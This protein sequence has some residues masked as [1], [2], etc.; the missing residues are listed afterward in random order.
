MLSKT[1]KFI[2]TS[3]I[4]ITAKTKVTFETIR[5]NLVDH[6]SLKLIKND[7]SLLYLIKSNDSDYYSTIELFEDKISFIT[8]SNSFPSLYSNDSIMK[9]ILLLSF[10]KD[11]YVVELVDLYP[12][13]IELFKSVSLSNTHIIN[14]IEKKSRNINPPELIL[15]KRN[16]DL[17]KENKSLSLDLSNKKS[18]ITL[19]FLKFILLKYNNRINIFE[20]S[21]DLEMEEQHI[22]YLISELN[23]SRAPIKWLNKNE[24]A[25][26]K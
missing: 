14:K 23:N 19:L 13:L 6:K 20:L 22:R 2:F 1:E 15:S 7:K 8:Y 9:L 17:Q 21:K 18:E 4:Q 24:F 3:K 26:I 16:I 11:I 12:Y 25:V 10:M 5:S